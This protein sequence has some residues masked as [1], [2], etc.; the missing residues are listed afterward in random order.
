MAGLQRPRAPARRGRQRP[1]AGAAQVLRDLLVQPRRVLHGPRRGHAG[2]RRRRDRPPARG[3]PQPGRDDRGDRRGRPR[4]DAPPDRRA[5][6]RAP[7]RP[8][9]ARDRDPELRRGRRAPPRG[10]ERALPAPDLPR[11]HPAGRRA[12]SAVPLH[13]QPVAV[14]RGAGPRPADRAGDL[15]AR[16]GAEGDAAAL[17]AGRRRQDL[18]AA[19]EPDRGAPRHVVPRHGG[20]RL[21]RLPGHARRRLHGRRRGRRPAARRRAGAA[22]APHGRG[23]A[24]RGRRR[25]EPCAARAARARAGDRGGRA[26]RGRRVARPEGSDGRRRRLRLLRAALQALVPG[27]TAAPAA[28]RGRGTRRARRD[29]QGRHPRPPSLRLVRHVGRAARRAGLVRPQGA[30]DQADRVPHER[31]LAAGPRADP[32]LRARQAG[33]LPRRAQGPLRRAREHRLGARDGGGRRPRRLRAADA[34]DPRQ[35]APDRPPR[36]RRRAPLRPRRDRELS[37][38]RPPASTPT[39]GS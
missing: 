21:R 20:R 15:R 1:A 35:G 6:R 33:G 8:R 25:H 22:P 39:S 36:G 13:L 3:R 9:R 28:R 38:A 14:A 18:R 26:V 12:R 31:R 5:G 11:P 17:P 7:A 37:P 30:R 19:R 16:E 4:A 10:A 29:A 34:Q 27:H 23:R 24:G 2:V 32:R